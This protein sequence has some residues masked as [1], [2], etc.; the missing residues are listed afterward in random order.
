[1]SKSG[2]KF[3]EEFPGVSYHQTL[4]EYSLPIS[5]RD[6]CTP[7]SLP[8][9]QQQENQKLLWLLKHG[10]LHQLHTYVYIIPQSST[11]LKSI[12]ISSAPSSARGLLA[13]VAEAIAEKTGSDSISS[14]KE[15]LDWEENSKAVNGIISRTPPVRSNI[16]ESLEN[17]ENL[18]NSLLGRKISTDESIGAQAFLLSQ[19]NLNQAIHSQS[20]TPSESDF[21]SVCSD[22]RSISPGCSVSQVTEEGVLQ[23]LDRWLKPAEKEMVLNTE[24]AKNFEDLKLFASLCCYF[25]GEH[26]LEE[27]MYRANIH[28]SQLLEILDKFRSVLITVQQIDPSISFCS[29]I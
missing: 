15:D 22:D 6:K 17:D 8:Q 1:M 21:G 9:E 3:N 27:I 25:R 10:L 4:A 12:S 23:E 18:F 16:R 14:S 7:M 24:S 11:K 28:R 26:P 20:L 13:T 19:K 2:E 5:L 29:D